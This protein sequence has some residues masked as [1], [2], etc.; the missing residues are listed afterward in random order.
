MLFWDMPFTPFELVAPK[1][2][3]FLNSNYYR[4]FKLILYTKNGHLELDPFKDHSRIYENTRL[5]SYYP[6]MRVIDRPDLNTRE[7]WGHY[8]HY[9]LCLKKGSA[10]SPE[11][12]NLEILAVESLILDRNNQWKKI[13]FLK[14]SVSER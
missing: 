7:T 13:Q 10:L 2:S 4:K 9:F 3:V 12:S 8:V 5:S 6:L 1:P 14:C 11:I